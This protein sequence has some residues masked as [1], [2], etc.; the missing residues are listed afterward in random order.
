MR[1]GGT[2]RI[3]AIA[4]PVSI[5]PR[6]VADEEGELV[7][8]ALFEP[9]VRLDD[10]L[11]PVAGAAESW[12]IEDNGRVFRFTLRDA[13]FHD[14][15]P[16]T[17]HDFKRTFDAIA[18]GTA[19]P[20]SY[21][22]FLLEAVSG[23]ADAA[24]EG[25]GLSGVVAEDDQTLT[26]RLDRPMP[27]F[28]T[29]LA[30]PSLVPLPALADDDPDGFAL[31]PIGNG[32]FE[33]LEPR[34][35]GSFL[36]LSRFSDHHR[37]ALLDEV[38]IS[39]YSDDP[40]HEQQWADL[41]DGQL[42]VAAIGP[43]QLAEAEEQFGVSSDG[44]QGPGVLDGATATV[45]LYGFDTTREPFDDPRVRRA[46]S[47]SIDRDA[48]ADQVMQG[49]R[50]AADAIVPP[51]VP[52][53]QPGVC[54]HCRL[55]PQAARDLWEEA[56]PELDVLTLTHNRG[57][58]HAAIAEQMAADIEAALDIEVELDADDLQPFVLSVR[59]GDA[60]VFRL[61]WQPTEPDPGSYLY[62][63]FHSSQIGLDNLTRYANDDVDELLDEAR[64]SELVGSTLARYREAER[65]VVEDAAV[66]PLLYY[67]HMRVVA[68]DV[69][70]FVWPPLGRVDLVEVWLDGG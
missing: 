7:V 50:I 55:D 13:S 48:L 34:E 20:P 4:D 67:R 19:D 63:L 51:P 37:A 18:D 28:L 39:V 8:G 68:P 25:G 60:P 65:I 17:A 54:D 35:S 24:E 6:Y 33:M 16:V 1:S 32:P 30:N 52:G 36:R 47:M 38:L 2:L 66:M 11:R 23:A 42:H 64:A 43:D 27:G 21:L 31:Q 40:G 41:L 44:Y 26:I 53:S 14:G 9:L 69:Q 70:E 22:G 15:S 12:E 56:D 3:G 45:Y 5:D 46:L 29:T 59:R 58:T 57:S 49:T 10:T 61:G 62:P